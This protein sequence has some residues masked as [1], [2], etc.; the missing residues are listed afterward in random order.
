MSGDVSQ[1][2]RALLLPHYN[3]RHMPAL[4]AHTGLH[5]LQLMNSGRFTLYDYG[6][7]SANRAIYGSPAPPDIGGSYHYMDIPVD[8]MAGQQDGVVS[9]ENIRRHCHALKAAGAKVTLKHFS[10]GHLDFTFTVRDEVR[11]Y[12]LSR[13]HHG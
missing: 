2:D 4:S 3:P 6:S 1:W 11:T 13:L 10:L 7:P 5:L 8:L 9:P 12:I